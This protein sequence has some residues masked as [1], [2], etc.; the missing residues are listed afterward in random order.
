V[1]ESF[2]LADLVAFTET[3]NK[4]VAMRRQSG[5]CRIE[6]HKKLDEIWERLSELS[7]QQLTSGVPIVKVA[8]QVE[9]ALI[10]KNR[11]RCGI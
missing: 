3:C 2:T 8:E 10:E 1:D 9:D 11:Q 6:F 4:S 7:R 5:V